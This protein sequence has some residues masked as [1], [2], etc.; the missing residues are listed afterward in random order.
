MRR[1][2]LSSRLVALLHRL[3]RRW[4]ALDVEIDEA[5]R[6]LVEWAEQSELCRRA[7]TV[8]GIGP[9]I[10]TAVVAAVGKVKLAGPE[11]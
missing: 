9:I 4:L 3:R 2:G 6:E 7:E 11:H 1:N 8:P 10:A 5:T